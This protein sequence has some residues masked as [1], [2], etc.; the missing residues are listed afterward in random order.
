M[1]F[2]IIAVLL[3][4]VMFSDTLGA[5]DSKENSLAPTTIDPKNSSKEN[6]NHLK[7]AHDL[8]N[9]FDDYQLGSL[10]YQFLN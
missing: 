10:T 9:I 1:L 6:L 3:G 7:E 8:G 5:V 2:K 4:V